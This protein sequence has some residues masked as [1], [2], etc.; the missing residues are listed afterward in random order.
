MYFVTRQIIV[1]RKFARCI[2][3]EEYQ[4]KDCIGTLDCGHRYHAECV[5]QWLLVMNMC[6]ICKTTAL[7]TDQRHWQWAGMNKPV[8][9]LLGQTFTS[10]LY[11]RSGRQWCYLYL[12]FT[13]LWSGVLSFLK[14]YSH[15]IYYFSPNVEYF[16][17][18]SSPP[19]C[20]KRRTGETKASVMAS[21]GSLVSML[22]LMKLIQHGSSCTFFRTLTGPKW[23]WTMN[24]W[25]WWHHCIHWG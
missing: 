10:I 23:P 22:T 7:S 1:V 9:Y 3:Q 16:K 6:P 17:L 5:H 2:S 4:V 19:L 20:M 21:L 12:L 15:N 11:I 18:L 8:S 25:W 13:L 14:L 24:Q